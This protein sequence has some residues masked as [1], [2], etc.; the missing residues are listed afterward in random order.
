MAETL[1]KASLRYLPGAVQK[2]RLVVDQVRGVSVGLA[3]QR[4]QFMTQPVAKDVAKLIRSA[5]ANAE[6]NFGM[7]GENL[8]IHTIL[9]DEGPT[10]FA[11]RFKFGARGRAKP[12]TRRRSH[13]TVL[14]AE[15]K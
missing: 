12:I 9:A 13:I 7:D 1:V 11:S 4:L 2:T 10:K 15:M 14:L 5:M 6:E 8:Y 3:L